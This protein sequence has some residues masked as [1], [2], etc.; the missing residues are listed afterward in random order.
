[1]LT[2]IVRKKYLTVTQTELQVATLKQRDRPCIF[3]LKSTTSVL[4]C[5]IAMSINKLFCHVLLFQLTE[6]HFCRCLCLELK[7]KRITQSCI[8]TLVK[9]KSGGWGGAWWLV[10]STS[11]KERCGPH[12]QPAHLPSF[13]NQ[14]IY[15]FRTTVPN[16]VEFF[17]IETINDMTNCI[18]VQMTTRTQMSCF[19]TVQIYQHIYA[20]WHMN[21]SNLSREYFQ[22]SL[23]F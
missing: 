5:K 20:S 13:S 12:S 17:L 7:E 14:W 22:G 9:P 18:I 19:S 10:A 23:H 4:P 21:Y 11:S 8:L 2:S 16:L 6:H 3:K 15:D 1:M